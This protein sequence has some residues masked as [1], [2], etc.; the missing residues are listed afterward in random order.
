MSYRLVRFL[1]PGKNH[2][3]QNS[4]YWILHSQFP[5]V[6]ILLHSI[7]TNTNFSTK[8]HTSRI[9]TSVD[10]TSGGPPVLTFLFKPNLTWH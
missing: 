7:S 10:R 2:F 8:I 3:M 5:L 6:R 4:Y 1:G 9:L